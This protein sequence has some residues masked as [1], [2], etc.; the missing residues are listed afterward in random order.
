MDI[1]VLLC[2]AVAAQCQFSVFVLEPF[3]IAFLFEGTF[4]FCTSCKEAE[5]SNQQDVCPGP[6]RICVSVMLLLG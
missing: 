4:F 1:A 5:M 6:R 2:G 3:S